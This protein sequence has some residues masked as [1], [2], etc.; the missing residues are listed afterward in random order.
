MSRINIEGR[1]I[2]WLTVVEREPVEGKSHRAMYR[3][4]CECGNECSYERGK[5][6]KGE[7][8]ACKDCMNKRLDVQTLE[9]MKKDIIETLE[10]EKEEEKKISS[11]R[12]RKT[13]TVDKIELSD[14]QKRF[15]KLALAGNNILVDACIGSGK[16]TAIQALCDEFSQDKKVLYLTYNKLLKLDAKKK[17]KHKNVTVTNYH[18]YAYMVLNQIGVR[19]GISDL[20]QE[21]VRVKPEISGYDVLV[22]DEYQDIEQEL[23]DM[24]EQIKAANPK[25]QIIAVGDMEQKIY[26]KTT[27]DVKGFVDK[28]LGEYETLQFTKCFRLSKDLAAML[29][30]VWEKQIDGVNENCI[31]EEM[32]KDSVVEFLST[33]ETK[34]VLC[35]GARLGDM[36]A[37]L[38]RL[39]LE[40]PEKYNKKT[41]Y[42]SIRDN[43]KS[44]EPKKNSAI[45]TT[46]DSSKGME[47]PICVVFD[48]TESY[49]QVRVK[50][51]YQNYEILRNIF[52]VAASRGK[53]HI[54][55]VKGD[56]SLLSEKTLSTAVWFETKP[57]QTDVSSMFDFKYKENVELCYDLLE[58]KKLN[59]EENSSIIIKSNDEL[60]DLSPCIGIYQEASYFDNYNIEADIK[61]FLSLNDRFKHLYDEKV[62]NS[63]VEEKIL[64]LTALET[65]Q[66]RYISQ[67]ELPYVT[68]E[69]TCM[70]HDRLAERLYKN[71]KVQVE[72]RLPFYDKSG[73]QVFEACGFADAVKDNIVYELKFVNELQHEHFLQCAT[74]ML[75]LGLEKG[76][77]WNTKDNSIYEISIP[78]RQRL[79]DEIANTVTKGN[80]NKEK[81]VDRKASV[82]RI[83][84]I[85]TETTW[86]DQVMSIGLVIASADSF[87][88]VEGKY[89]VL[90]PEVKEGGMFS[91]VLYPKSMDKVEE[92]TR[93]QAVADIIATLYKNGVSKLFA[94]NASFD[95]A[96]LPELDMFSWF[97]IMRI[98]ANKNYNKAISSDIDCYKNG[99]MKK[100]YGVEPIIQM[101][102]G[103]KK[104]HEIHNALCDA[105]D[106]LSIINMLNCPLETYAD[107]QLSYGNRTVN[108]KETKTDFKQSE[109]T[110][111]I[112]ESISFQKQPPVKNVQTKSA[113]ECSAADA[114]EILNVSKSTIYNMIK[115]GD[116]RAV[117]KGNRYIVDK[118]S[119]YDYIEEM[120]RRK[121]LNTIV[122]IVMTLAMI[123]FIPFFLGH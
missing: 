88:P 109:E 51:I 81:K 10:N 60:I 115:R 118:E 8:P 89:Y 16:T 62:Q 9:I 119:V 55:F 29:G 70:I 39:E 50:N 82:E 65:R 59:V 93:K 114:A 19:A 15:I 22:I 91:G 76:Y 97:D 96:H 2:G 95:K 44:V 87:E 52:C 66:L 12:T 61:M 4:I 56:E 98:A 48:F 112:E 110:A 34:D 58:K 31:V 24:L 90:T 3:C 30:R 32:D 105:V 73:N 57:F 69:Q 71:E 79:I 28:F 53:Q 43:D 122:A 36:S 121:R 33:Q 78:D 72:C 54:I 45:F 74:Y 106:E 37:T 38:N 7:Y 20:I 117:K 11:S 67:V 99:K 64:F 5:I 100:G 18:G 116:I 63:S 101:L 103:D 23:A 17:I 1:K 113:I 84:V 85:D 26:D 14:E 27:L 83:A 46:Y 92:C 6:I 13:K 21:F 35:L 111:D 47:R 75:A 94:Y 25:M 41:V 104:Y 123:L 86:S 40:Y 42:A 80:I 107:A 102:S 108:H 68:E 49:W 77:L 120:K